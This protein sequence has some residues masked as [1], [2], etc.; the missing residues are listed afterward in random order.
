MRTLLALHAQKDIDYTSEG[1]KF[2]S[3]AETSFLQVFAILF[4]LNLFFDQFLLVLSRTTSL[5]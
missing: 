2:F 3:V 1:H 5:R 4:P